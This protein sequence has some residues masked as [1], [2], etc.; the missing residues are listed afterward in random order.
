MRRP[1]VSPWIRSITNASR[2]STSPRY[3]IGSGT[4][5]PA[6][7]AACKHLELVLERQRRLVDDAAG[8]AAD[9]QLPPAGV[10]RP[11]LLRGAAGEQHGALD[12][13]AERR[14]E[15]VSHS[16]SS[17]SA[18][19][20]SGC[21]ACVISVV[22]PQSRQASSRSAIRSFGPTSAISSTSASGTIAAASRLCPS[23]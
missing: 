16:S 15:G 8:G 7:C 4:F 19:N 5:T 10:D 12:L 14:R 2:P 23:R 3:A 13:L 1:I 11:G 22:A 17:A 20:A 9:Q 18:R 21:R 6:S